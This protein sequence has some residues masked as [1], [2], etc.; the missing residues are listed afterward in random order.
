MTFLVNEEDFSSGEKNTK[1]PLK[2][3]GSILGGPKLAYFSL[4]IHC[5]IFKMFK[6][7]LSGKIEI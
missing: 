5:I 6:K 1:S 3:M 4:R 2:I 7:I